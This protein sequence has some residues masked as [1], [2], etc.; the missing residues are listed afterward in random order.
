MPPCLHALM[1]SSLHAFQRKS[2]VAVVG[3][4]TGGG[5][6]KKHGLIRGGLPQAPWSSMPFGWCEISR[7]FR[8]NGVGRRGCCGEGLEPLAAGRLVSLRLHVHQP[9][10]DRP[11]T[12]RPSFFSFP[13]PAWPSLRVANS[14]HPPERP[15]MT[16]DRETSLN[17]TPWNCRSSGTCSM[18]RCEP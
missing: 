18:C 15:G 17:C 2:P 5:K 1:P 10:R 9:L 4:A 8:A 7:W 13:C 12:R 14:D 6:R 11:S 3:A 16:G